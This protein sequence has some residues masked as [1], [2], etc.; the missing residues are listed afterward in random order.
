MIILSDLTEVKP[1]DG[2]T[3]ILLYADLSYLRDQ[4]DLIHK[5]LPADIE[6]GQATA[7]FTLV[8]NIGQDYKKYNI[9]ILEGETL[10]EGLFRAWKDEG[11]M[12]K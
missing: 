9:T 8:V 2:Y 1:E 11:T 3:V 10:A 6:E 12:F 7:T 4:F 5:E